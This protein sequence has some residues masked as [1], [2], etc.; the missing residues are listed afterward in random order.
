MPPRS[1]LA[2]LQDALQSANDIQRDTAGLN[3]KDFLGL[4]M[5]QRACERNFQII[6]EALRKIEQIDPALTESITDARAIIG[7]RNIVVHDYFDLDQ[8]RVWQAIDEGLPVL[9]KELTG[10]ISRLS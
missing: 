7:F 4:S 1:P 9:I 3:E 2:Y 5:H 10:L 8:S 6:G